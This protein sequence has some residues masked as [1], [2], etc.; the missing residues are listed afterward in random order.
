MHALNLEG[1]LQH[2]KPWSKSI[3]SH[4]DLP[5][6]R[7]GRL[8]AQVRELMSIDFQLVVTRYPSSIQFWSVYVPCAAQYLDAVKQTLEQIDLIKRMV[9]RHSD[10]LRLVVDAHGEPNIAL[11]PCWSC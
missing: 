1:G 4:T 3:W 11:I 10:Y 2:E 8:G 6:L 9:Q 7:Q 5:R